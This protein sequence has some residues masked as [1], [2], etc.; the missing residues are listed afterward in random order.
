M[1]HKFD[2]LINLQY[3]AI[4][5]VMDLDNLF[6]CFTHLRQMFRMADAADTS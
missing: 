5:G 2:L 3:P 1:K 4:D 6:S